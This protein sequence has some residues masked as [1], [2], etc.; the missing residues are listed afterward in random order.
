MEVNFEFKHNYDLDTNFEL[1][2]REKE[3][4]F[5]FPGAK[6]GGREGLQVKIMPKKADAW[7][8]IF[9]SRFGYGSAMGVYSCPDE[10]K[11]CVV[12]F[13][14]A[15]IGNVND[16]KSWEEISVMP[17]KQV[18][19]NVT[20]Q[21]LLFVDDTKIAAYGKNG[22]VWKTGLGWDDARVTEIKSDIILGQAYNPTSKNQIDHFQVNIKTGKYKKIESIMQK[23]LKRIF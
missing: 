8:G 15:Y 19:P 10:D 23:L 9:S 18:I 21:L 2:G 20:N 5:Y 3:K 7:I 13:G 6:E 1:S 14:T 22:E 11:L 4:V 12:Y 16:P 17:V